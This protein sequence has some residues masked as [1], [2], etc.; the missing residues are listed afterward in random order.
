MDEEKMMEII[1]QLTAL[2]ETNEVTSEQVLCW[3]KRVEAQRVQ[4]VLLEAIEE[5]KESK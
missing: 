2:K 4:K 5:I 3:A 1:R